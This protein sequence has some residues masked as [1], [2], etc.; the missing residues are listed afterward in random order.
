MS[1]SFFVLPM[2]PCSSPGR[3]RPGAVRL[4]SDARLEPT[5]AGW[6]EALTRGPTRPPGPRRATGETDPLALRGKGGGRGIRPWVH[7]PDHPDLLRSRI[8]RR[9]PGIGGRWP[10]RRNVKGP[11]A[12][13]GGPSLWPLRWGRVGVTCPGGPHSTALAALSIPAPKNEVWPRPPVHW[14]G[15]SAGQFA[16]QASG[17][18][19][20]RSSAGDGALRHTRVHLTDQCGDAGGVRRGHRRAADPHVPASTADDGAVGAGERLPG[21]GG[22]GARPAGEDAPAAEHGGRCLR[23]VA[24]RG[25]DVDRACRRSSSWRGC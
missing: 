2:C 5:V 25:G 15:S 9:R 13:A 24:A 20:E 18:A 14:R 3:H 10:R 16:G 8:R 19:D 11:P 21:P 6:R 7:R 4:S 12:Q 22:V 23:G 1:G 17:V